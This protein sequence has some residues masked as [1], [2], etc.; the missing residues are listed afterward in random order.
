[1]TERN[2]RRNNDHELEFVDGPELDSYLESIVASVGWVVVYFNSLEDHVAD[3]VRELVLRDP[4]QDE[5]L[6]V[7]LCEMGYSAKCRALVQ[8]YGQLVEAGSV[9]ISHADTRAVETML[10]ECASR[11]NEYAHADW[12]GVRRDSYVRVKA[13]S[14][15]TGV[16]HRY[17]RFDM[18]RLEA[19]VQYINNAR[20]SLCEFHDKVQD[21]LWGR[22]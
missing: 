18:S 12:I 15:K 19:D 16:T 21:Q 4:Y 3:F 14:S 13:V 9:K 2:V 6:E 1:M 22:E 20:F 17:R 8:L 5:R 10:K 11:R 7:F